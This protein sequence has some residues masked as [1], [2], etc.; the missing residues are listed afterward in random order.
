M[1]HAQIAQDQ[2]MMSAQVVQMDTICQDIIQKH[3]KNAN[4]DVRVAL[5]VMNAQYAMMDSF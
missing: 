4:M 1:N 3:A 2:M 5:I